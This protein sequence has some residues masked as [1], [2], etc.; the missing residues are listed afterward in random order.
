M[1]ARIGTCCVP[2]A[3]LFEPLLGSDL[4]K[5]ASSIAYKLFALS[6]AQHIPLFRHVLHL[7]GVMEH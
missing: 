6:G 4:D 3:M 5:E 2:R 1:P 7:R